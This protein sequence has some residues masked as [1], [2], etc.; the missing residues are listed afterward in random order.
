M[1]IY[2]IE[3]VILNTLKEISSNQELTAE[4]N[5]K[6][7]VDIDSIGWLR[8]LI[9]LEKEYGCI[10]NPQAIFNSNVVT[11]QDFM[12]KVIEYLKAYKKLN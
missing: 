3:C 7:D 9:Q 4:C 2:E 5:I 12:D 8:C 6:Q 10:F 1:E 11:I